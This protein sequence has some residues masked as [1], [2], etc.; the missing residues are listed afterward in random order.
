MAEACNDISAPHGPPI[1]ATDMSYK[2]RS[3]PPTLI[4]A[5]ITDLS[6][7]VQ[8]PSLPEAA[9]SSV[10]VSDESWR[11]RER[12]PPPRAPS[13]DRLSDAQPVRDVLPIWLIA[14]AEP[15]EGVYQAQLYCL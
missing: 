5:V 11:E 6:A 7:C 10:A 1:V 3:D 12:L 4:N 13:H 2:W 9:G 14:V 8:G 15:E